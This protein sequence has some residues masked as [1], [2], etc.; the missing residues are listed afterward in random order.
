MPNRS[1]FPLIL[2]AAALAVIALGALFLFN[3]GDTGLA[4]VVEVAGHPKLAVD[5][6]QIDFGQVLVDQIVRAEFALS[7]TGDQPLQMFGVPQVEAREG[8]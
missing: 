8:C 4:A 5:R 3:R 7:N 1:A 2:G 6:D